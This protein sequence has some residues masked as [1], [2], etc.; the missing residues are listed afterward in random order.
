MQCYYSTQQIWMCIGMQNRIVLARREPLL[1]SWLFRS[2]VLLFFAGPSAPD[3]QVV[4]IESPTASRAPSPASPPP[5]APGQASMNETL[6]KIA[7][8][9]ETS[10]YNSWYHAQ[11][12]KPSPQDRIAKLKE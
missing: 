1:R 4:Q 9:C 7:T 3:A 11:N 8:Q 5:L 10:D 6:E 2:A 12:P